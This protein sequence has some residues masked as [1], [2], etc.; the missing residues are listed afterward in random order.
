[1]PIPA[2]LA[3]GPFVAGNHSTTEIQALALAAQMSRLKQIIAKRRQ[4]AEYLN[5]RFCGIDGLI[6]PPLD[7]NGI[8]SSHHLYL[9]QVDPAKLRG[10]VQAL[11]KKL[12]ERQLVQIPHFAPLYKFSIMRQ[13]GYDTEALE[14]SCP[15]AEEAFRHRFTHLPLYDYSAEQLAYMADG[16]IEAAR[17]IRAGK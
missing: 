5:E 15:V 4:A 9:L 6:T 3:A 8:A 2:S 17:E 13:L 11:K 16:V 1:M 12:T 14:A 10:D 7:G